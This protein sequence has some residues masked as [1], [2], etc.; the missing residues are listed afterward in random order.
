MIGLDY[1]TIE[2]LSMNLNENDMI[3]LSGKRMLVEKPLLN[4]SLVC[5]LIRN[6]AKQNCMY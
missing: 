4:I 3:V 5:L 2:P 6:S 1:E